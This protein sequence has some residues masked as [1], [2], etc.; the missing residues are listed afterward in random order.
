MYT[1]HEFAI[2][3]RAIRVFGE[4]SQKKM[5]LEEI[6]ELQ[7]EICKSWRGA[8]NVDHIAEEIADV[9]IM[10]EQ[11]KIMTDCSSRVDTIREQKLRRLEQKLNEKKENGK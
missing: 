2:M 1:I 9:E 6:S 10:L 11:L 5:L 8:D 7:K 3:L 4:D